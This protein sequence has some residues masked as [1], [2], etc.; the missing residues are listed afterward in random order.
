M[1]HA[2]SSVLLRNRR[3]LEVLTG[4]HLLLLWLLVLQ[5]LTRLSKLHWLTLLLRRALPR[6]LRGHNH[7]AWILRLCAYLH[8]LK[9]LLAL[10]RHSVCVGRSMLLLRQTSIERV[11]RL[12]G[13]SRSGLPE[14]LLALLEVLRLLHL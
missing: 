3:L 9:L 5:W 8:L 1:L 14:V 10:D 11:L 12:R 6:I 4:L 13:L 2:G 7:K